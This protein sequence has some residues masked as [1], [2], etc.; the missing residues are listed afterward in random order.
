MVAF[1]RPS[2]SGSHPSTVRSQHSPSLKHGYAVNGQ[3]M[4]GNGRSDKRDQT[5]SNALCR[6]GLTIFSCGCIQYSWNRWLKRSLWVSERCSWT[7]SKV[8]H[9][10][11]AVIHSAEGIS[12]PRLLTK[13]QYYKRISQSYARI[14]SAFLWLAIFRANVGSPGNDITSGDCTCQKWFQFLWLYCNR[15]QMHSFCAPSKPCR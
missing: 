14:Q 10:S 5:R 2:V 11:F 7:M 13:Y 4:D 12:F 6:E 9:I 15:H 1:I 8:S 3:S